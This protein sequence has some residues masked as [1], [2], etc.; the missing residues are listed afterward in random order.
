MCIHIIYNSTFITI[1]YILFKDKL[2]YI[3]LFN[4][5]YSIIGLL[6]KYISVIIAL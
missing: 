6:F 3:T 5:N 1:C 4:I 2:Y